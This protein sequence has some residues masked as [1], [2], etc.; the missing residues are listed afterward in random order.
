MQW[1][2]GLAGVWI[3]LSLHTMAQFHLRGF[4]SHSILYIIHTRLYHFSGFRLQSNWKSGAAT[5]ES[6][7]MNMEK[8][9]Q[10]KKRG[11]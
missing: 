7:D 1:T 8:E 11:T 9:N 5:P 2:P 4:A 10:N 6:T 3:P